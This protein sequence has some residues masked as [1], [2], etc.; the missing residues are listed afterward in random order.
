MN[1]NIDAINLLQSALRGETLKQKAI[2]NNIAN[3]ETPGY[4][5][6]DVKFEEALAKALE[7]SSPVN[8]KEIEP[9]LFKPKNT[10]VNTNGNDVSI[11]R[12]VGE[13]IKNNLRHTA[14]VRLLRKKYNQM[15][16]AIRTKE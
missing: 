8:L 15:Q 10:P 16:L 4:R 6:Y 14:L 3:L 5:R 9:V 1:Q 12:E 11:E 13:M 2:A 7:S